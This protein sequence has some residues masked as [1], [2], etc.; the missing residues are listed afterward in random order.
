MHAIKIAIE[1]FTNFKVKEANFI[2]YK[3]LLL[4]I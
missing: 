4:S 1:R 2:H 3:Y